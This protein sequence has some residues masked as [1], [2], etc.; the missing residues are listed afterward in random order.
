[1]DM[2]FTFGQTVVNSKVTGKRTKLQAM[3]YIPGKMEEYTKVTGSKITCMAKG[4]ISGQMVENTKANI[5][6]IKKIVELRRGLSCEF[7]ASCSTTFSKGGIEMRQGLWWM[8]LCCLNMGE[9]DLLAVDLIQ[10]GPLPYFLVEYI[11][12]SFLK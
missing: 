2:A 8:I 5:L 3:E 9:A 1:M 10:L 11:D 7:G 6:M 4:I 12:E